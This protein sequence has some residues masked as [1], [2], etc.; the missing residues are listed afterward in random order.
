MSSTIEIGSAGVN[1]WLTGLPRPSLRPRRFCPR[2]RSSLSG[3]EAAS[4]GDRVVFQA[5]VGMRL[6]AAGRAWC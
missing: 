5:R 4:A 2:H 3:S 1:R 6:F